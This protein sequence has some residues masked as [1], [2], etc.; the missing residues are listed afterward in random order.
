M[1]FRST[2]EKGVSQVEREKLKQ[3]RKERKTYAGRIGTVYAHCFKCNHTRYLKK[4]MFMKIFLERVHR[5]C[6]TV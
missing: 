3:L 1:L 2:P 6:Y 4:E 5:L